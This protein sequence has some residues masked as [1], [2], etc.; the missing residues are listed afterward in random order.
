MSVSFWGALGMH[1]PH[2]AK[3][4]RG[5]VY[6]VYLHTYTDD[7]G[8]LLKSTLLSR[9]NKSKAATLNFTLSA[10]ELFSDWTKHAAKEH[11]LSETA[12]QIKSII[13]SPKSKELKKF[14]PLYFKYVAWYYYWLTHNE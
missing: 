14:P 11:L 10:I 4:L 7:L 5:T 3:A 8:R 12:Q 1:P 6:P 13:K 9:Y 2:L